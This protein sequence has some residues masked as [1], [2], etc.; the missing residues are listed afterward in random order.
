MRNRLKAAQLN[1]NIQST[2]GRPRSLTFF[3]GPVCFNQPNGF[4]TS[5]RLLKL[6]S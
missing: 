2:F 4:S 6:I 5:Q 3:T 1:T